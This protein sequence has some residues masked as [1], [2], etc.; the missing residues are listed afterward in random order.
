VSDAGTVRLKRRGGLAWLVLD[1]PAARNALTLHM[2]ARGIELLAEAEADDA[3]SAIALTGA[4]GHFCGGG[5]I[6][7][8][9]DVRDAW[10]GRARTATAQALVGALRQAAK[11]TIAVA[12]GSVVGLGVS[13]FAACDLRLAATDARFQAGFPGVGLIPD[14]GLL[15]LLPPLIGAGRARDWLLLNH[16]I[17][18]AQAHAWGLA[19]RTADGEELDGVATELGERLSQLSAHALEMTKAGLRLAADA[20]WETVLEF[21]RTAQGALIADPDARGRV[22][23]FLARREGG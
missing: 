18:G 5:D 10:D 9:P 20:S 1:R 23:A 17:D 11:P 6:A 14:G 22:E 13:V 2:R 15:H 12:R 3:V 8:M 21:E 4:A 19:S 16:P 7:S